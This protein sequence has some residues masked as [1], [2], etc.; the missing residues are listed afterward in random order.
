MYLPNGTLAGTQPIARGKRAAKTS[1]RKMI[2]MS[3]LWNT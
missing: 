2:M 3:E 1:K